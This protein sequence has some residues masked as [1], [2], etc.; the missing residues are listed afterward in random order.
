M[1]IREPNKE[2]TMITVIVSL[3][4]GQRFVKQFISMTEAR[5]EVSGLTFPVSWSANVGGEK[6]SAKPHQYPSKVQ[7]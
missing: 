3:V 7:S 1:E 4:N 6:W 2:A 5:I